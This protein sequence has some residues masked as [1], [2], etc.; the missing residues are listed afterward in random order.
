MHSIAIATILAA[1]AT[2]TAAAP[3]VNRR[4]AYYVCYNNGFRGDCS[5]DPCAISW[6]PDYKP[7][8]YEPAGTTTPAPVDPPVVNTPPVAKAYYVCANNGFR[9]DC[10]VD[11]CALSWCP[12]YISYTYTPKTTAKREAS[13]Q[14]DPT[15][16]APGTGYFQSCSNGFRGCCKGDACG[17]TWCP[18]FKPFTFEPVNAVKRAPEP[19][20]APAPASDPT[21]CAAGTGFFQSCS[22]GFRGC[23][24]S[25]ACGSTWCA[26]YKPYTYEPVGAASAPAPASQPQTPA[27]APAPAAGGDPTVCAPNT[28]FYQVCANGFKGCCKKDACTLG[29][30][31]L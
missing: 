24:K 13:P 9:G 12:D 31:P 21:V 6:C 30:C 20:P 7:F 2:L 10:T 1:A 8:T 26:D 18:D 17:S 22:N 29:Y 16:C 19:A 11:P 23:C 25:D 5:V 15:V 3:S 28:G 14:S 27:P 4:G